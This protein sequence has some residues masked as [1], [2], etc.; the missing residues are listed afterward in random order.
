MANQ[1]TTC[2]ENNKPLSEPHTQS[3]MFDKNK[4]TAI[5]IAVDNIWA[6]HKL[7]NV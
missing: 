7:Y 6:M 5:M 3:F 1:R 4:S 2:Y